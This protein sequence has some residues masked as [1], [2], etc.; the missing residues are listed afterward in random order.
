[1]NKLAWIGTVTSII[2]SFA[3][4]MAQYKMGYVLFTA[5]SLSWLIVAYAR[6]DKSLGTLNATFFVAN[7][8]GI[9]NNFL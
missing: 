3:V 6:R 2:G 7:I 9:Y 4:A 1:M 8:L 5:G